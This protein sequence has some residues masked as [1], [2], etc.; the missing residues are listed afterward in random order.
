MAEPRKRGLGKGLGALI[1]SDVDVSDR[2]HVPV[3]EN[4]AAERLV[5]I[6][7]REIRPNPNQPRTTFN[8]EGLEELASS[9]KRDGVQEPVIVRSRRGEY[10]LVSGE[11][12]VRAAVMADLDLVP[13]VVREV[14]DQD[15]LKL[16]LIENIQ[17]EDL[18]PIETARAY[19]QLI[20]EFGWTQDH[21]AEEVGKKRAT[22]TNMLRLLN[23][24]GEVQD[25]VREGA[26]SM[27]HARALLAI[28]SDEARLVAARKIIREGL[29]VRQTEKLGQGPAT[30]SSDNSG[31]TTKKKDPNLAA[32]EDELR[33]RLGT[34]VTLRPT[35]ENRGRIEIEYFDLDELDRLLSILRD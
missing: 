23:L 30:K 1:S 4:G 31:T 28:E 29:S 25:R 7:P 6:D 12:R 3:E 27:G 11:R 8:E 19:Q 2:D 35:G 34:R 10:E 33:K 15:M 26:L 20:E 18:N 24:P 22:V 32:I 14:A 21:L 16:G 13:A 9:L 17:R 5:H